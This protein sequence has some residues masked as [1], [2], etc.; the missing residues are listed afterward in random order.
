M[1]AI[2][3]GLLF[4]SSAQALTVE[5][6]KTSA[7]VDPARIR[8]RLMHHPDSEPIAALRAR[9]HLDPALPVSSLALLTPASGQWSRVSPELD[10]EDS[11][12]RT[13]EV[14][15]LAPGPAGRA[16]GGS[17]EI[18]ALDLAL[19]HPVSPDRLPVDSVVILEAL[20]PMDRPIR[21]VV[22]DSAAVLAVAGGSGGHARIDWRPEDER[23]I[24][25]F[26]L[27]RPTAVRARVVDML[28][29]PV[30][31]LALGLFA[32]GRSRVEWDGRDVSGREAPAGRY[33]LEL[34]LGSLTYRE[35]L[36]RPR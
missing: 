29:R 34:R 30:R 5:T 10:R 6:A 20:D 13:L 36:V 19:A 26:H 15:A 14:L 17:A 8:V 18:L 33:V 22:L 3:A 25:S 12:G 27:E 11:D 7:G 2:L 1:K 21:P 32:P 9:I 16:D 35:T 24:V 31:A 4:W 28:G 23:H